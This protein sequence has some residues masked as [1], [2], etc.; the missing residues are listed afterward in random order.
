MKK[1]SRFFQPVRAMRNDNA[2]DVRPLFKYRID[3]SSQLEPL[4]GCNEC[5]RNV[6]KL[7]ALNACVLLDLGD[8]ADDLR[9]RLTNVVAS[10]SSGFALL[11]RN[12]STGRNHHNTRQF[13]RSLRR[14]RESNCSQ[15]AEKQSGNGG[16]LQHEAS[17]RILWRILATDT[18]FMKFWCR[19]SVPWPK[20]SA[21]LIQTGGNPQ[22]DSL[23]ICLGLS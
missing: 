9:D 5:A 18:E 17:F 7:H 12:R 19:K 16:S 21:A 23:S 10:Q 4:T 1:E 20:K 13:R 11:P 22:C 3:I 2:G 14:S 15:Q 6:R 8:F